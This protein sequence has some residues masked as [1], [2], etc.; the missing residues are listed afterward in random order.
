MW[1]VNTHRNKFTVPPPPLPLAVEET[2]VLTELA[3]F[4]VLVVLR[5]ILAFSGQSRKK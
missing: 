2:A 3:I 5:L 4:I 1:E